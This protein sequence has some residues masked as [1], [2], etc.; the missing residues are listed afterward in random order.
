[1]AGLCCGT[2]LKGSDRPLRRLAPLVVTLL[3]GFPG[4]GAAQDVRLVGEVRDSASRVID[5][6]LA[7]GDYLLLERDTVLGADALVRQDVVIARA[8]VRLEGMI[9]GS[10]AVV[11][12]E[13]FIR[14]GAVV[15]GPIA[16]AGGAAYTSGLAEVGPMSEVDLRTSVTVEHDA[17][18]YSVALVHPPSPRRLQPSGVFGLALPT[19]D[20]VDGLTIGW[21]S[22]FLI[23]PSDGGAYA[24]ASMTYA[25]ERGRV[26]G[27]AGLEV[28]LGRGVWLVADIARATLT[29][30]EWIRSPFSNSLA[31]VTFASDA[32]DYHDS[33][34]ATAGVYVRPVQ[35]LIQGESFI[36]P[37]L[38]VRASR[39]R[40][41]AAGDPW[42]LTGGSWRE[43]P[44]IDDG[45]IISVIGGAAV[46]WR[47]AT[48]AFEGDA[49][50]EWTPPGMGD[51]EVTQLVAEGSWAMRGLWN[52]RINFY[53]RVA[54]VLGGEPLPRQ[55]WTFVG[56]PGTLP[57]LDFGYRRGDNL[58]F[59]RSRYGVPVP[60]VRL[61]IL[62][63]AEV[64]LSHA[65]GTAWV[66]G[67]PLP[68]WDQNLGLGLALR[69]F[70]ATVWIDPA[71]SP[72][73]PVLAL[74]LSIRL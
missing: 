8:T 47:G 21:G 72:L 73:A 2:S 68:R 29:N 53:S 55:R 50:I 52:H 15:A 45:E 66:T 32:R 14:P 26:G 54:A 20:R 65:A 4:A 49:A 23:T 46:G 38:L 56:G 34:A 43:N 70:T 60:P 12:G 18:G 62:G 7:R 35:P 16:V 59:L 41:V 11:G 71:L 61:P 27:S 22:R 37:R 64:R 28:P 19:Y 5:R 63:E 39:D 57:A 69:P 25:T 48:S 40:S 33:D 67:T 24:R 58:V 30:E 10:V 44:P 6:V 51:H 74:S 1:M 13:L 36:G 31:A 17:E 9:H 42:T 3:M